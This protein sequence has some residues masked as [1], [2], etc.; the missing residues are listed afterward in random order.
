MDKQLNIRSETIKLLEG[1]NE[2][3]LR[4]I[5]LI[6]DISGMTSKPQT[7]TQST[8][9]T[10]SDKSSCT[11]KETISE[12]RRQTTGWEEDFVNHVSEQGLISKT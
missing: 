1:N 10:A 2:K 9:G 12:M 6:I 5:D 11:V 4:N 3:T 7:T 8:N